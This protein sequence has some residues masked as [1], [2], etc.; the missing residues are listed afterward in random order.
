[1]L[2]LLSVYCLPRPC[3]VLCK[4]TGCASWSSNF[5]FTIYD[6]G[7]FIWLYYIGATNWK[8]G[9]FYLCFGVRFFTYLDFRALCFIW[10][11]TLKSF[12]DYWL[13]SICFLGVWNPEGLCIIPDS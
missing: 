7:A 9:V 1:M 2:N 10:S 11:L 13:L 4:K 3:Y 6:S 12:S 5:T 8:D